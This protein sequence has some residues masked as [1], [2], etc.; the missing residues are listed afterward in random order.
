MFKIT[1]PRTQ[2]VVQWRPLDYDLI[3][4]L[5]Q[6]YKNEY[7]SIQ[8]DNSIF[9]DMVNRILVEGK[10]LSNI[11][12]IDKYEFNWLLLYLV[13][14]SDEEI[15]NGS[16]KCDNIIKKNRKIELTEEQLK[17]VRPEFINKSSEGEE[18]TDTCNNLVEYS[19]DFRQQLKEYENNIKKLKIDS[20]TEVVGESEYNVA[21]E[22]PKFKNLNKINNYIKSI[23]I[24]NL[25]ND[26][27]SVLEAD[28]IN[29]L[30]IRVFRRV[31]KEL[32]RDDL[33]VNVISYSIKCNVCSH[34]LI[35]TSFEDIAFFLV[36]YISD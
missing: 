12:D 16:I 7:D 11:D 19:V 35:E 34:T 22:F 23:S 33:R 10:Y 3:T 21:L 30:P 5:Q 15:I 32:N 31:Q 2:T 4:T 6:S 9:L 8:R 29:K 14:N 27:I 26:D 36:R 20:I 13:I 25:K 28:S 1:T 24:R 17:N 18:Y